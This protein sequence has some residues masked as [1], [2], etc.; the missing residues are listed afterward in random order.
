[1]TVMLLMKGINDIRNLS[2]LS[3]YDV[4]GEELRILFIDEWS[5]ITVNFAPL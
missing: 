2:S 3:E 4:F 1:M 5:V